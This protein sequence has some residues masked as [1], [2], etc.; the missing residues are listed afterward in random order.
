MV[1]RTY[2]PRGRTPVLRV[3]LTRD[4]LSAIGGITQTGRLAH[5]DAG[6]SLQGRGCG[7]VS[8]DAAPQNLRQTADHLGWIADPSRR[9][10][11]TVPLQP[12]GHTGPSGA[13]AWLR[14]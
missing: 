8:E 10:G 2:A 5:A 6:A 3:K 11:Q 12:D 7:A 9:R 13:L 1:V 14:A 4:H